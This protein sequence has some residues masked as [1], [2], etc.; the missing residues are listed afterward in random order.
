MEQDKLAKMFELTQKAQGMERIGNDDKALEYYLEIHRDYSPN[1]SALFENPIRILEKK[2]R[3]TEAKEMCERAID[4]V[5]RN[6]ITGNLKKFEEKLERI[7]RK[8]EEAGQKPAE[9]ISGLSSKSIIRLLIIGA[10]AAVF[11]GLL[12]WQQNRY[13]DL[14]VNLEDQSGEIQNPGDPASSGSEEDEPAYLITDSMLQIG[15]SQAEFNIEVKDIAL[16]VN[17]GTLAFALIVDPTSSE[18]RIKAIVTETL[19]AIS[20]AA[21]AEYKELK[22]PN[23]GSLGQIYD[24]YDCIISVGESTDVIIMKGTKSTSKRFITWHE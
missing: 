1:T 23:A 17:E 22:G 16:S 12:F 5:S 13:D 21:S 4:L 10:I 2:R 20:G 6:K 19:E 14:E 3:L 7:E 11:I 15:I 8:M 24:H 9:T 18:E